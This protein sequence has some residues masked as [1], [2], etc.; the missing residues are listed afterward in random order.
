MSFKQ[1][2][3]IAV[4]EAKAEFPFLFILY[5]KMFA[6]Q[7]KKCSSVKIKFFWISIP[8]IVYRMFAFKKKNTN[9]S[10]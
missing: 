6:S 10:V 1:W 3:H 4:L 9:G 5:Y 8:M 2:E 7:K